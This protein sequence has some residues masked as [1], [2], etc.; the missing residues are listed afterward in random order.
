MALN[1]ITTDANKV[2]FGSAANLDNLDPFTFWGWIRP[3]SLV[4]NTKIYA[5]HTTNINHRFRLTGTTGNMSFFRLRAGGQLH[6]R[7]DDDPLS[8]NNWNFVAVTFDTANAAG[9]LV[10]IYTGGLTALAAESTYN[11]TDDF[12]GALDD[13]SAENF[14]VGNGPGSTSAFIGDIAVFG[15]IARELTL[16]ELISLQFNPRVVA[17]TRVFSHLGFNG[18]GTQ[19]DWSGNGSDGTVTGTTIVDHVPLVSPFGYN[20]PIVLVAGASVQMAFPSADV[21]L[22]GWT[23]SAGGS[24]TELWPMIDEATADDSDFIQ[25]VLTPSNDT[26]E[27]RLQTLSDPS[28]STGHVVRYRYAKDIAQG[29]VDL[30]VKLMD[31]VTEIA[32]FT[33]SDIPAVLTQANQTLSAAQADAISNYGNLRLRF[34]ANQP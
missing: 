23:P 31:G 1:F 32:S 18:T 34:T 24:P 11:L 15:F 8:V 10:N 7:T 26:S 21:T 22:G 3:T 17:D 2:D 12:S 30:T 20:V 14:V 29:R 5:K 9:E 4:D 13:D 19:P 6:Y 33:H 16:D 25:S 27:V 28:V